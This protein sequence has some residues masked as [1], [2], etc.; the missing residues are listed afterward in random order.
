[1]A[2][3][4]NAG[5]AG[6]ILKWGLLG[7]AAYWIYTTFFST[8]ATTTAAT[9]TTAPATTTTTTTPTS[10]F[11]TLDAIYNRIVAASANDPNLKNGQMTADQ[12]N[13]YLAAQSNVTPPAPGAVFGSAYTSNPSETM[14]AATYWSTMSQYL[15]ANMGMSGLGFYGGLSAFVRRR[16][17][18]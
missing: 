17:G 9:T 12:W 8:P 11:N 10:S 13:V 4:H 7:V 16:A 15:A 14:T 1:M 3:R 18:R 2:S 5:G 6:E